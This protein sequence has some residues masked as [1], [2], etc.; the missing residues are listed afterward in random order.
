MNRSVPGTDMRYRNARHG[1]G[2]G[3]QWR[4]DRGSDEILPFWPV[5]RLGRAKQIVCRICA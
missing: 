1:F 2:V 3:H 5:R 4:C